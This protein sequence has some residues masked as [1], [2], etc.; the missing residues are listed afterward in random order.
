MLYH[1]RYFF[2]L[3][4]PLVENEVLY[5]STR[6]FHSVNQKTVFNFYMKIVA[7]LTQYYR[8]VIEFLCLRLLLLNYYKKINTSKC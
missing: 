7:S 5:T 2:I 8:H 6:S 1:Y 3:F 4:S